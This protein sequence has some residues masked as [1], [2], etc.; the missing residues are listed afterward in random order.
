M[1]DERSRG[2]M[3]LGESDGGR[4][5]QVGDALTMRVEQV[6]GMDG[7]NGGRFAAAAE[8]AQREDRQAAAGQPAVAVT[9]PVQAFA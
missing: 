1:I 8:L 7:A 6:V 9:L 2:S 3:D 5:V 4:S